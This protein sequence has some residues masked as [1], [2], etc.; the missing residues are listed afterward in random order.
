VP[1]KKKSALLPPP[2][3]SK[4]YDWC[5]V[6]RHVDRN[7]SCRFGKKRAI[8]TRRTAS[9]LSCCGW[10]FR[11]SKVSLEMVWLQRRPYNI[12]IFFFFCTAFLF[13]ESHKGCYLFPL[14][15]TIML[16]AAGRVRVAE[17]TIN[18]PRLKC[19]T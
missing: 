4:Q 1:Y 13:R 8:T 17:A 14:L 18:L 15:P 2:P 7:S 19:V 6:P 12:A 10:G 9:T 3:L 11:E 16:E 5:I